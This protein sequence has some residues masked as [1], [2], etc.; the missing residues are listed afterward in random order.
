MISLFQV[1][2][3]PMQSACVDQLQDTVALPPFHVVSFPSGLETRIIEKSRLIT[4]SNVATSLLCL[5]ADCFWTPKSI[6]Q[7]RDIVLPVT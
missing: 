6:Q 1:E 7:L 5:S 3:N 4:Q 2:K